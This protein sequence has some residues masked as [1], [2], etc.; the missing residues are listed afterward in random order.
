MVCYQNTKKL[1]RRPETYLPSN[2]VYTIFVKLFVWCSWP[3]DRTDFFFI[4]CP[5]RTLTVSYQS[6]WEEK[7]KRVR[8]S[9]DSEGKTDRWKK[10][11]SKK[12]HATKNQLRCGRIFR[13]N[14]LNGLWII[15]YPWQKSLT[16][17]SNHR[18]TVTQSPTGTL[19]SSKSQFTCRLFNTS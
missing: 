2:T 1:Y 14:Q 18:P 10:E 19:L 11:N 12:I 4:F 15:F 17:R 3:C 7:H 6:R 8:T 5:P 13:N 9:K 16:T